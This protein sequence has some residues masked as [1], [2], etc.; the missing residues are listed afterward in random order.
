[1]LCVDE[2]MRKIG[3]RCIPG[4]RG[5]DF[6]SKF[7]VDGTTRCRSGLGHMCM[8][9]VEAQLRGIWGHFQVSVL[10]TAVIKL[11]N[12]HMDLNQHSR[13]GLAALIRERQSLH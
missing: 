4:F 8:Y 6:M 10:H 13:R 2:A 12:T 7:K 11:T 1:M 3:S 9:K 5:C